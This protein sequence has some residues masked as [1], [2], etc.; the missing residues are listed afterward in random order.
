MPPPGG[1]L[2][3]ATD[4]H[5]V[6]PLFFPGGDIGTLAVHGTVND[7]A[8]GGAVPMYLTVG[9]ILEEGLPLA[10]L[11]RIVR[12]LAQAAREAGVAV[13]TGDTKVVEQGKGDGVFITTTGIGVVPDG[14]NLSG[15]LAQPG[16]AVLDLGCGLGL[17]AHVLR[18]R[19]GTQHYLG[20]DVDAGKIT[21][22]QRAAADL[23]DVRFDCVDVQAPLPAQSGHVLL[24]DVLQ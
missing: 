14:V 13:I 4:G 1:R 2:A 7:L 9:F 8:M 10:D 11:A 12:S 21:R 3:V 22:A 15:H 24:L 17:F 18:Q 16:D 20:V 23:Q 6:S 19:G 5:V